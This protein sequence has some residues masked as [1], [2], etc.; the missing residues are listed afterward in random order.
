MEA[1]IVLATVM[2][3]FGVFGYLRGTKSSLFTAIVIW[4][5]LVLITQA[6][7][8]LATAV[9]GLAFGVVFV[10]SGG[11][12]AL[13]GGGDRAAALSD[14]FDKMPKVPVLINSDGAGIGTIAIFVLLVIVGFL[15]GMLKVFKSKS[16]VWG[17][18]IGLANGYVLS[19]FLLPRLLP[20]AA[21]RLPLPGGFAGTGS[22][23]AGGG[24]AAPAGPSLSS[25]LIDSIVEALNKLVE[26]GQ[27]ALFIAVLIALFV[28]LATRLGNRKK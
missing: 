26:G 21:V 10:L 25:A 1:L 14:V 28:L 16:S 7:G 8:K 18:L 24:I 5:G 17:L 11:L 19:A 9:N 2:A 6:G 13:G 22:A 3:L 27:I 4:V 12:G 15:L 20:D 23:P